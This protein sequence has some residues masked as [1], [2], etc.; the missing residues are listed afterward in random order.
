MNRVHGFLVF[1]FF[2]KW[3]QEHARYI[4]IEKKS[5]IKKITKNKNKTLT[6]EATSKPPP[7]E[8]QHQ[9]ASEATNDERHLTRHREQAK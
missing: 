3:R 9:R 6:K 8:T 2:L 1:L 7:H 4:L 5:F